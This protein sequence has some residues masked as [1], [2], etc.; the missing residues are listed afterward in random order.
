MRQYQDAAEA[1]PDGFILYD[2]PKLLDQSREAIAE[3]LNAPAE[4]VV[5]VPNATTGVNTVLRNLVYEP[6][7][8]ILYT[9]SIYGACEKTIQYITETTPASSVRVEYTLPIEDDW[10]VEQFRKKIADANSAGV[11]VKVAVFDTIVSMPG[12]RLPFERLVKVCKEMGVLSLIDGAHGVGHVEL[13]LGQ[14]DPDFL[15]SNC[16]K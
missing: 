13:D 9:S 8:K 2:Y 1:R 3:L 10:L 7:D 11:R 5:F 14:L 16:H 12:V 15:V 6:G 4:T